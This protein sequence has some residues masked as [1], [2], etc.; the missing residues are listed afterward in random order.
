MRTRNIISAVIVVLAS[1]T[2]C[3]NAHLAAPKYTYEQ[4]TQLAQRAISEAANSLNPIPRL[5]IASEANAPCSGPNDDRQTHQVMYERTYWLRDVPAGR[6]LDMLRQ[7]KEYWK[8]SGYTIDVERSTT[9]ET[10]AVW[11][12]VAHNPT[13]EFNMRLVKSTTG[14]LSL[15]S[16]SPCVTEPDPASS[17]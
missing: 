4:A 2:G 8:S 6:N 12:V 14:G 7:L 15:S 13:S 5:E 11:I 9:T 17:R 16:Q 3:G 1:T 10:D